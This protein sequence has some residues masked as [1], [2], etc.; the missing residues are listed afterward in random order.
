MAFKFEGR[1]GEGA[2]WGSIS[3]LKKQHVKKERKKREEGLALIITI[4]DASI[5][6]GDLEE[7]FHDKRWS[8]VHHFKNSL[9]RIE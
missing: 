1:E 9:C 4:I 8:Q 2:E 3:E 5:A 6:F 7:T